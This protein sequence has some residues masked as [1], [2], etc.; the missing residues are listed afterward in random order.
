MVRVKIKRIAVFIAYY[1]IGN[2]PSIL[3]LLDLLS[4]RYKVDLFL[5]SVDL[6]K[7]D[8]LQKCNTNIIFPGHFPSFSYL[9]TRAKSVFTSY[10]RYICIDPHG[11]VLCK[12]LFP[13]SRPIYY[14][15]ELHMKNDHYGLFYPQNVMESERRQINNI[16]GL[17]IQSREKELLFRQDY[18]LS[19][20]IPTLVLP[21]TYKGQ[22]VRE[23][24]PRIRDRYGIPDIK[25][26]ALHLGGIAPWF[27][28]IEI[29][30]AFSRLENW[31]LL[32][33]GYSEQKYLDE[34][35]KTLI[36]LDTKNVIISDTVFDSLDDVNPIIQSCDVGIAWY[37]DISIGFRTAGKSSGKIP[38][39]LKFGLPVI[40]TKYPSTIEALEK[41]GCGVCIDTIDEIAT[42][43]KAIE[44][45]Y[46]TYSEN[47]C[48]EYDRTY[49]FEI[50]R[51]IIIEFIERAM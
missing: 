37:K 31:V 5:Q 1:S 43:L 22:S 44:K 20:D 39:Y 46:A 21:I 9:K 13:D 6:L 32:F 36:R 33:H 27:S 15:L 17:M 3:N 42:A 2:S 28:C 11:F 35:K 50:Y 12:K 4:D 49:R 18:S 16:S 26:I 38:A 8:V 10:H 14:S 48:A 41:T 19:P 51:G 7:A 23:K 29:A 24:S 40:A 34:L 25:K 30:I 45:D 47:A